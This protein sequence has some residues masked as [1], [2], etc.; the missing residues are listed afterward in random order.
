MGEKEI[1]EK[2]VI[3]ANWYWCQITKHKKEPW[4][5]NLKK[6][7]IANIDLPFA[8]SMTMWML[9][10]TCRCWDFQMVPNESEKNYYI[11]ENEHE[12]E[13]VSTTRRRGDIKMPLC[14]SAPVWKSL[15]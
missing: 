4:G 12:H 2:W 1:K 6:I 10:L 13:I 9:I 3:I 15:I 7:H 11:S 8:M 5:V 14:R